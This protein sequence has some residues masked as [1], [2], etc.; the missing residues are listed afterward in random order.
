M[1]YTVYRAGARDS[2]E[3][4]LNEEAASSWKLSRLV[5]GR[6][7]DNTF[8][9]RALFFRLCC[10]V[11]SR[12]CYRCERQVACVFGPLHVQLMRPRAAQHPTLYA[13]HC[14]CDHR[15]ACVY[16]SFTR[17]K[18]ERHTDTRACACEPSYVRLCESR[19][20]RRVPQPMC[21]PLSVG[22][23]RCAREYKRRK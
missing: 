16:I 2:P 22:E 15:V 12:A 20:D 18:R 9:S 8:L 11:S 5:S 23:R 14:Y 1:H 7:L 13:L 4:P 10:Y 19:W 6:A 21:V 3:R 17:R